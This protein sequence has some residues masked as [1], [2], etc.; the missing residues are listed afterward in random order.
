VNLSTPSFDMRF[1]HR[2]ILN[3]SDLPVFVG[4]CINSVEQSP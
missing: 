3:A 1:V 4:M 2:N